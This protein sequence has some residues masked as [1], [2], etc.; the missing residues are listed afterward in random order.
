[1]VGW[2][3]PEGTKPYLGALLLGATTPM[4]ASLLTR[5]AWALGCRSR[6]SPIYDVASTRSLVRHRLWASR[7][8][9]QRV[10]DRRSFF[11]GCI[12]SSPQL[13]PRSRIC[14]GRPTTSC[15]T[16]FTSGCG[17]TSRQRR[18]DGKPRR[19]DSVPIRNTELRL[20]ANCAPRELAPGKTVVRAKAVVPTGARKSPRR[21]S[22]T[23]G[24]YSFETRLVDN[25]RAARLCA[26]A[27]SE[28]REEGDQIAGRN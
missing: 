9:A 2:S 18:L 11:R 26:G 21:S 1:M 22:G 3:D 27:T 28:I 14:L 19:L 24:R 17:R 20:W 23:Y 15:N 6:F 16:R 10:S 7:R 8:R 12:G 5:V 13:W 25:L 4:M